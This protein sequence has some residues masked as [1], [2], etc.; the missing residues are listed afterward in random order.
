MSPR[1]AARAAYLV[2]V[3]LLTGTCYQPGSA[4]GRPGQAEADDADQ[5]AN[6]QRLAQLEKTP[7][8]GRALDL[9][10]GYHVERGQ[11]DALI[12]RYRDRAAGPPPDGAAWM[13]VGLLEAQRG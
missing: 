6:R 5:Q 8:R 11:L 12:K 9:V 10:Y 1:L 4:A 3:T 2:L 13:I 7:R